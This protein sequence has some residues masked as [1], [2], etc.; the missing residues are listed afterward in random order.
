MQHTPCHVPNGH[1]TITDDG[2]MC[3]SPHV[4]YSRYQS[5]SLLTQPLLPHLP[6]LMTPPP[7]KQMYESDA[8]IEYL[9]NEY[10]DG[11]V[12]LPLRMGYFTTLTAGLALA[13]R[14]VRHTVA[15][16]FVCLVLPF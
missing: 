14:W 9:F 12:P 1:T 2:L 15:W 7:G 4:C 5:L 11:Q 10:G 16:S 8:I 6:M 13:P 3:C